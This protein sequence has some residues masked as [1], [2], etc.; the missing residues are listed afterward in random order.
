MTRTIK[1]YYAPE[2]PPFDNY[3]TAFAL[4]EDGNLVWVSNYSDT[5]GATLL[6]EEEWWSECQEDIPDYPVPLDK[7]EHKYIDCNSKE[8]HKLGE[9]T[10]NY[11][12]ENE[13]DNDAN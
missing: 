5:D 13:V 7:G 10:F 9:I 3:Q 11:I 2:L 4:D 12:N 1:V 8:L 6:D